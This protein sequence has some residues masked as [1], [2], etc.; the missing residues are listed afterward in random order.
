MNPQ[1]GAVPTLASEFTQAMDR[2]TD[3]VVQIQEISDL[4]LIRIEIDPFSVA[5]QRIEKVLGVDFPKW[6]GEVTGDALASEVL[7]G[8]RQ[9][10]ALLYVSE[11]VFLLVSRVD[12]VKMG[13]A[14]D[15]ALADEPGLILDVSVNRAVIELSG[16]GAQDVLVRTVTFEQAPKFFEKGMAFQCFVG[17]SQLMIW[18]ISENQYLMVPRGENTVPFLATMLDAI[19][20]VKEV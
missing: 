2:A 19:E 14:L 13:R 5:A 6:Q 15:M 16:R 3:T 1:E 4:T 12:G 10:V 8:T 18:R 9:V 11:N 7:Y 17:E 20:A